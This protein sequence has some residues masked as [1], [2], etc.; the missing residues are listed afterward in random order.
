M[1]WDYSYFAFANIYFMDMMSLN[2][3][4][5]LIIYGM[6]FI[7]IFIL[8]SQIKNYLKDNENIKNQLIIKNRVARTYDVFINTL[9]KQEKKVLPEPIITLGNKESHLELTIFTSLYC[10]M[11]EEMCEII[12]KILLAYEDEIKINIFLKK[13]SV[14]E[15]DI[16]LYKLHNIFLYQGDKEF[17]KALSFWFENRNMDTWK[18]DARYNKKENVGAFNSLN[19]WF[20]Q[21]EIISTPSIFINGLVYPNE[22]EKED[23]Y[24]HIEGIIENNRS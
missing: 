8:W 3:L 22:F 23:L 5:S 20:F 24:Y 6:I 9:N 7:I 13:Q 15:K 11:C 1:H 12:K 14:E 2:F 17:L 4:I 10:K 19:D 16:F 18:M 21:N